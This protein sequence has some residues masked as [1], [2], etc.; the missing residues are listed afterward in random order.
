[1]I[2][3]ATA[4]ALQPAAAHCGPV[5]RTSCRSNQ[6]CAYPSFD[7][8]MRTATVVMTPRGRPRSFADTD[9]GSIVISRV[10]VAAK[11]DVV[12]VGLFG[13]ALSP[14]SVHAPASS[15]AVASAMTAAA[16]D[17]HEERDMPL[18]RAVGRPLGNGTAV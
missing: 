11:L 8:R 2:I 13:S 17:G 4:A 3:M 10:G 18:H 5:P 14:P 7:G 6:T 1:V 12:D 16:V 15:E 9:R